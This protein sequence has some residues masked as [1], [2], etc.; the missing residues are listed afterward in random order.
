MYQI[1]YI[2][3][4]IFALHF[5]I[6]FIYIFFHI[7]IFCRLSLLFYV[8]KCMFINFH[9]LA[10]WSTGGKVFFFCWQS[11]NI[12]QASKYIEKLEKWRNVFNIQGFCK[13]ENRIMSFWYFLCIALCFF[14]VGSWDYY[15]WQISLWFDIWMEVFEFLFLC[16]HL[17]YDGSFLWN[18]YIKSVLNRWNYLI[19]GT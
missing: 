4:T 12:K 11:V 17:I 6:S 15:C 3:S 14:L 16:Y 19:K 13:I 1:C 9:C 5:F 8:F 2:F 10:K 18:N 7:I